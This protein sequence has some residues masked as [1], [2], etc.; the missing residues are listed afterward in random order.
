MNKLSYFNGVTSRSEEVAKRI[1]DFGGPKSHGCNPA[2]WG[3]A[4]PST[5]FTYGNIVASGVGL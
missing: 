1:D 3:Y 4:T 5:P 2:A